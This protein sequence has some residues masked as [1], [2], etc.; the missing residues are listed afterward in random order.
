MSKTSVTNWLSKCSKEMAALWESGDIK[1]PMHIP[2]GNESLLY[3][4]FEGINQGDVVFSTHR[5]AYHYLLT[6]IKN[7]IGMGRAWKMLEEKIKSGNCISINEPN[8][9][10]YSTAILAGA[11]APAIGVAL[12]LK[13]RGEGK[14]VVCFLGDGA[15]DEGSFGEALR[16]AQGW[17]LPCKF[18]IEDNNRSVETEVKTRWGPNEHTPDGFTGS[19]LYVYKYK[20]T[21][22]HVGTGKHISFM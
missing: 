1:Y 22:P 5:S 4:V 13:E 7:K 11:C 18:I 20:A 16:Y 2:G 21:N 8:I 12:S 10:F 3:E 17:E 14:K 15:A 19:N 9:N 6:C